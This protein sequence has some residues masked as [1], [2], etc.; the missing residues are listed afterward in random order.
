MFAYFQQSNL[1]YKQAL[2]IGIFQLLAL[3]PGTS[4][5]GATIIGG[6]L[7]GLKRNI[8][9]KFTFFLAIPVMAGAS[10]LKLAKFIIKGT[11]SITFAS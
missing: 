10:L 8:A 2:E 9:A 3:I 1:Q 7:V 4:R 11:N 5:S 6:L